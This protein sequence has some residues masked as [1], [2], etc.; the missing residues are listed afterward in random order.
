MPELRGFEL[1]AGLALAGSK[2]EKW[3]DKLANLNSARNQ[4]GH[5]L[6]RQDFDMK[7]RT[8]VASVT[9]EGKSASEIDW[10]EDEAAR[11]RQLRIAIRFFLVWLATLIEH[12]VERNERGTASGS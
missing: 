2:H 9:G 11:A 4:V 12:Y 10:P 5:K 8:F 3:R 7:I 6:S 1:I